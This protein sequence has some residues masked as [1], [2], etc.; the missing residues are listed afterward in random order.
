M[1]PGLQSELKQKRAFSSAEQE[2]YLALLRTADVLETQVEAKLK[3]FGL[4]GTQ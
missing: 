1:S 4:T 3:G 2:A